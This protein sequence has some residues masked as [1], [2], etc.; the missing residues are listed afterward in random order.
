[1]MVGHKVELIFHICMDITIDSW[2]ENDFG[3]TFSV[4]SNQI[5]YL[6][7][8]LCLSQSLNGYFNS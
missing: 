6:P 3:R 5:Y 8:G 1:M 4:Y 7:K 2:L